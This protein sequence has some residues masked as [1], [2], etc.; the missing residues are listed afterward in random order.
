MSSLGLSVGPSWGLEKGIPLPTCVQAASAES[1]ARADAAAHT[2]MRSAAA[3]GHD[4]RSVGQKNRCKRLTIIAMVECYALTSLQ[5]WP[6]TAN[7]P[8][9]YQ[10]GLGRLLGQ[11]QGPD[12]C[13]ALPTVEV[14]AC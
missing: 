2:A 3:G 12:E 14:T 1:Y 4:D 8:T 13:H 11:S 10:A 7:Q 6:V 5:V 9:R